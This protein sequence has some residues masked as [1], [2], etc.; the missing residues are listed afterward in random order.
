MI[1]ILLSDLRLNESLVLGTFLDSVFAGH[2]RLLI[3]AAFF[4]LFLDYQILHTVFSIF[5]LFNRLLLRRRW[6]FVFTRRWFVLLFLRAQAVNTA[7]LKRQTLH[8][9]W[10]PIRAH[11]LLVLGNLLE[12]STKV[13][14]VCIKLRLQFGTLF[15]HWIVWEEAIVVRVWLISNFLTLWDATY[16]LV[17]KYAE[18]ITT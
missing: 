14:H 7:R 9:T 11:W 13:L 2:A 15:S 4:T 6:L 1:S 8:V 3:W 17:L 18:P 5:Y 16:A 10:Q 12:L